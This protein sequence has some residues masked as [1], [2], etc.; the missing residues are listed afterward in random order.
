ML[1]A[2]KD[3]AFPLPFPELVETAFAENVFDP[4]AFVGEIAELE[5]EEC[6]GPKQS[7]P[8][9]GAEPEEKHSAAAITAE[10]LHGGIIQDSGGFA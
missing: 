10:G 2:E 3:F 9:A 1:E 8:E 4:A 7:G 5:R 6:A